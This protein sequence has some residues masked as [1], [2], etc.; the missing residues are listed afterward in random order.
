M[1]RACHERISRLPGAG[2]ALAASVLACVSLAHGSELRQAVA[3]YRQTHERQILAQLDHLVTMRS[4]AADPAGLAAAAGLLVDALR[5]RGFEA[6]ALSESG[7]PPLVVGRWLVAG[8]AR[9]VVFYAHYDG[10]PVTASQWRS[11]PFGPVLRTGIGVDAR[12][13][14]WRTSAL[15]LDPE[16][17]LFG[18]AAADDKASIIAFLTAFDALRAAGVRP[19]VNITVVWDGEEEAGSPHLEE[20]LRQHAALLRADLW[21]IGDVPIHQSGAPMLYFGARGVIGLDLTLYGANRSLHD[22]HY[23][24]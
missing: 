16:G 20:E 9:T 2:V 4:V 14:D 13:I 12:V 11:D 5:Q 23:G 15:P 24:N 1:T 7:A 18:R 8:S 22:G 6:H 21:L 3:Y 17:R 19:A 10:Q